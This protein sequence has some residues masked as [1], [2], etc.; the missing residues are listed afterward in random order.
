V[1]VPGGRLACTVAGRGDVLVLVHGMGGTRRTWRHL[2]GPLSAGYTV[3]APDLPGH[4]ES[5]A[6][7]GD[8]SIGAH[9]TSLRDLLIVLGHRSAS[10]VGHSL[11]GGV[12]LGFA[13]QY[14]ERISRLA[15]IGSGGLGPGVTPMLRAATLPGSSAVLGALSHLPSPLTRMA[16]PVIARLPGLM[17]RQDAAA[18]AEALAGL[19]GARQR[20]AFLR[21]AAAVLDWRGQTIDARGQ[22]GVLSDLP[23]LL[24]WG[25][26]DRTIPAHQQRTLGH[27][28]PLART[29][30]IDGAGHYPHETSPQRVLPLLQDFLGTTTPFRHTEA[31]WRQLQTRSRSR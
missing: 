8:Y 11:G 1:E 30:E 4:G 17:A 2:I 9:A 29:H 16:L 27:Q 22:L 10:V 14:P 24:I 21:T 7:A 19:A 31:R 12:G 28:L 26:N 23:L 25:A 5:D 3:V 18:L 20:E 6:P 15:L 13:Y